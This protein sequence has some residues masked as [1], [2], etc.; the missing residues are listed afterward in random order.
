MPNATGSRGVPKYVRQIEGTVENSNGS[1]FKYTRKQLLLLKVYRSRT[2]PIIPYYTV[3]IVLYH[4][5]CKHV[6]L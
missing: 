6:I 5:M 4:D 2:V 1:Y 3:P